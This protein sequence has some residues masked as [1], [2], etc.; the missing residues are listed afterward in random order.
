MESHQLNV[1]ACLTKVSAWLASHT[2]DR[3]N[4]SESN[5]ATM[6]PY[7][8]DKMSDQA[9]AKR[10]QI[11]QMTQTKQ[12]SV[13]PLQVTCNAYPVGCQSFEA[14]ICAMSWSLLP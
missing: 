3:A 9:S 14:L 6:V 8:A 7:I 2:C 11:K 5:S 4:L 12:S 13:K 10:L 1:Q